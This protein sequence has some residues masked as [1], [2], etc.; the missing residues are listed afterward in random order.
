M[1]EKI[2]IFDH[3]DI[4]KFHEVIK[5]DLIFINMDQTYGVKQGGIENSFFVS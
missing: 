1:T 3:A 4:N 2:G 5:T